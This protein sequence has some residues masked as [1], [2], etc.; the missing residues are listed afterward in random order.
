[1]DRNVNTGRL[2]TGIAGGGSLRWGVVEITGVVEEARSR[3]DLSPV[4]AAALGRC[5]AGS[6]LLL[7]LAPKSLRRLILEVHGDG[8]LGRV[9]AEV[10][11]EGNLRGMVGEPRVDLP[12]T[13]AGKLAVGRGV[14]RGTLR[15]LR[16]LAEGG[17]FHSQVEL[18]SGEIGDDLAH[19]L[20][21]S[22]QTR[23]AVLL[24]VLAK[25]FGIAAAGGMIV[26]V[27]PDAGEDVIRRLEANVAQVPGV[28]HVVEEG[29]A[30]RVV[31][32]LLAGLDREVQETRPLRYACRC[33]R[34]KLGYHLASLTVEDRDALQEADGSLEAECVFCGERYRYE[35]AELV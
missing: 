35:P 27:M 2:E 24:G 25:P 7:S 13:P 22:E 28:S 9:L 20:D 10:D 32:L 14:G 4:A 33:S 5:L 21:Q 26:E 12:P 18:V 23:S 1:M 29:G 15:V 6:A 17:S 8:P 11:P 30:E 16:E 19:Y 34:E 3:L 31:E